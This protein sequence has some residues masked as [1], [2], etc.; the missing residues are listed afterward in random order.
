MLLIARDDCRIGD[1][2]DRMKLEQGIVVD[3][4]VKAVRP[5]AEAG[6]DLAGMQCLAPA[7]D[8]AAFDE[9]DKSLCYHIRMDS[10]I[11][12]MA[13]KFQCLIGNAAE[14][15]MECRAIV[16]DF[17]D[18]AGNAR[19]D[20]IRGLMD[21][22]GERCLDHD[23]V[24]DA[25]DVNS[26]VAMGARHGRVDL[27]HDRLGMFHDG[28][29]DIDRNAEADKALLIRRRHLKKGDIGLQSSIG[30][31]LRNMRERNRHIFG[32]T[33]AHQARAH[34]SRRKSSDDHNATARQ[35]TIW[36]GRRS[37]SRRDR[38][39]RAAVYGFPTPDQQ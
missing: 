21:I 33:F 34:R 38:H 20:L 28:H 3:Q 17:R 6:D 12:A 29:A 25:V 32:A 19:G 24:G 11:A 14:I 5:H 13:Q 36:Q 16:D 15:D 27:D 1:I 23:R 9:I 26:G 4:A 2:F 8:D 18:I 35:P 22:F 39:R 31:Q 30:Y 37:K 10:E 7:G